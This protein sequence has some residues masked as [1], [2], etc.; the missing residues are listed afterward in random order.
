[1]GSRGSTPKVQPYTPPPPPQAN[2][3]ALEAQLE[4]EKLL[5]R[6]RKGR[7]STIL[8]DQSGGSDDMQKKTLLGS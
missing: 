2:D 8:S 1:M 5:A 6:K 3:P 4:K 7:Q